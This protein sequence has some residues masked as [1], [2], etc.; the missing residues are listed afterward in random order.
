MHSVYLIILL[1]VFTHLTVN[2]QEVSIKDTSYTV[3]STYQK[4]IK[5]HPEIQMAVADTFGI[6]TVGNQVYQ[7]YGNRSLHYDWFSPED[8]QQAKPLVILVHGG[9]WRSGDK[10][11]LAPLA[12]Q[13]AHSGY[14]AAC[15]EYR[16]ST[17]AIYPAAVN[18]IEAAI[19]YFYQEAAALGV[20]TNRV[21]LLGCSAGATL[22][23]LVAT[24]AMPNTIAALIN[25]DGVVDFT[26]P[27]ESGKDNNPEKPSAA[28][29]F[30]GCTYTQCPSLWKEGSAINYLHPQ[31]PK[32][33]F[34]NSSVP[35]FH[36]GREPFLQYLNQHQIVNQVHTIHDSPHSFWLFQPWFDG[37]VDVMINFL[38]SVL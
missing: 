26:D 8:E 35:R 32:C 18:D 33:L 2:G 29:Q 27:N 22:A 16:L 28:A 21:V 20:D 11:M 13:L 24:T 19:A 9:G 37:S 17:E 5:N 31:M 10:S 23:S 15:I 12:S 34:L 1:S 14:L 38:D 30:F 36:A 3:H 25:I 7:S 6:N 4:L